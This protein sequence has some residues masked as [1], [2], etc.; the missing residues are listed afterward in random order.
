[1]HEDTNVTAWP[2]RAADAETRQPHGWVAA[3][4][5]RRVIQITAVRLEGGTEHEHISEVLWEG[6]SSS[7][8]TSRQA[9]VDWL[10]ATSA[11]QA[12]VGE[13]CDHVPVLVVEPSDGGAYVRTR[14]DGAW[15]DDLLALP[16]F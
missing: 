1:M 9:L 8:H 12:V 2:L 10:K 7:G 15:R 11:N 14:A 3:R 6:A 4:K 13:G 16:R 5:A